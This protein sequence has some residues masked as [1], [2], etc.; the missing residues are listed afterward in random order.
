[1]G[2]FVANR[3]IEQVASTSSLSSDLSNEDISLAEVPTEAHLGKADVGATQTAGSSESQSQHV[4]VPALRL[5]EII[6]TTSRQYVMR[7]MEWHALFLAPSLN[8]LRAIDSPTLR[9]LTTIGQLLG[10]E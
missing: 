3:G 2:P 10:S 4:T 5:L 8:K 7:Q 9:A 6:R 1:M